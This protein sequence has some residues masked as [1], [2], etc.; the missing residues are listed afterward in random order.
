MKKVDYIVIGDGYA[1]L[2]F[3]HQLLEEHKS[4]IIFS[5]GKDLLL[6]GWQKNKLHF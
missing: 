2:F 1:A 6:F 4:F 3:A 5:E